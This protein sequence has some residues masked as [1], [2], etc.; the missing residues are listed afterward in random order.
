MNE[1]SAEPAGSDSIRECEQFSDPV[2]L[3]ALLELQINL[4]LLRGS[5]LESSNAAG[6]VDSKTIS[7]VGITQR[8]LFFAAGALCA[9]FSVRYVASADSYPRQF[10]LSYRRLWS[11][12]RDRHKQAAWVVDKAFYE[13]A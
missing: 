3:R 12:P 7:S 13:F 11:F 5:R 10:S 9:G 2:R 1:G 4:S 8:N 6:R